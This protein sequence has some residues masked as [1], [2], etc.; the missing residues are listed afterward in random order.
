MKTPSLAVF[1]SCALLST[2]T[3]AMVEPGFF[4]GFDMN[5]SLSGTAKAEYEISEYEDESDIDTNSLGLTLGY[6]F[7]SNNR[8][9]ISRTSIGVSYEVGANEEFNGTDFDWQF[10]YGEDKIMPYWGFGL[11]LYTYEDTASP[12]TDN[13][14]LSGISFQLLGGMKLDVNE[15]VEMDVSYRV[16]SIAWEGV[17]VS[18][19]FA[20]DTLSLSH[21]SS[22]LN[23]GV[24]VKF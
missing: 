8:F 3:Q 7:T 1:L 16:K 23:F 18:N 12:I 13:E 21:T 4:V 24:A 5:T 2:S 15:H 9:Q 11:G 14:D 6:R 20:T 22:A 19:G 10:V 17:D